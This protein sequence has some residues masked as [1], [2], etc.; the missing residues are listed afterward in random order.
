LV[1]FSLNYFLYF[2]ILYLN[3]KDIS[4]SRLDFAKKLGANHVLLADSDSQKTAEQVIATLGSMPNISIECS[5]AES[6]I[7][8][9]FYVSS[10][11]HVKE[12]MKLL[13]YFRT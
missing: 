13:F 3:H 2:I 1:R 8:T 12:N 11:L 6:S 7:Q 5:G 4:Q 10:S 9:T